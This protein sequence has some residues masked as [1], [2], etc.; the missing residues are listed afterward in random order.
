[1]T[2]GEKIRNMTDAELAE[3]LPSGDCFCC[4]V[5]TDK[6]YSRLSCYECALK[7]LRSD[8]EE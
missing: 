4:P 1:M 5:I 8:S 2:N 3:L 7:W 6:N